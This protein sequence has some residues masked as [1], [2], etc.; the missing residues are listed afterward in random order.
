MRVL[1]AEHAGTCFGVDRALRIVERELAT[2][3]SV[4]SLGPIIH[5]P[6]VVADFAARGMKVVAAPAEIDTDVV[7][8]RSHGVGPAEH[9][10]LQALNVRVS[11]ATC[12]FVVRAQ[13]AAQR[14]GEH[15]GFVIIAN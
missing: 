10:A 2:G 6:G 1:L 14:L 4:S 15:Y 3:K 13:R 11:D 5:N 8:I 9:E 7:V 12:P